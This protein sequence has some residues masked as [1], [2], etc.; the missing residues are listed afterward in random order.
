MSVLFRALCFLVS[1]PSPVPLFAPAPRL[2]ADAFWGMLNI[3]L[4][5][6]SLPFACPRPP[7]Q[8]GGHFLS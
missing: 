7:S 4:L 3:D 5:C 2:E 6:L 8:D 1:P